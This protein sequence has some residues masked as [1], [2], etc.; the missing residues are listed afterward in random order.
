MTTTEEWYIG[1]T[2]EAAR[3]ALEK[4]GFDARFVRTGAE[5]LAIVEGFAGKGKTVG[6]GGSMTLRE[7]GAIERLESIGA[8]ILDHSRKGLS[9]EEK[10]ETMRAQLTCDLF[11]ASANAITL[12]G[13]ILN[14]DGNGNR[15]AA[16]TFGPRKTVIV[17]GVNKIVRDL[18]AAHERCET[19]ACPMNSKRLDLPNPCTKTGTCADC[20][21]ERRICRIYSVLKRRPMRSDYTVI[22]VG[23]RLG[24]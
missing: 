7:I 20:R 16:L 24:Y 3:A 11:L 19:I 15:V 22:I 9:P 14:V 12:N 6:I 17:A 1:T 10:L 21:S 4:N 5:A 2:G 8:T 23:E 13:E 18:D